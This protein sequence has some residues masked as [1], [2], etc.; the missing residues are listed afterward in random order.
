MNKVKIITDSCC[1]ITPDRLK[2]LDIDYV[3]M[4]FTVDGKT[5]N[6]FEHPKKNAKHFYDELAKCKSCSTSCV[7]TYNFTEIFTKYVSQGFD[8]FYI[9]LSGGLSATYSN[10]VSAAE[11]INT[12][13]QRVWVAD[14]LTGS[15][16]IALMIEHAVKLRDEGKSAAEIFAALD[17][18]HLNLYSIFVPG[19][20]NFLYRS[21]RISKLVA[22]IGSMLKLVPIITANEVGKLKMIAKCIGK[23]KARQTMEKFILSKADLESAETIYIG[24]TGIKAEAEAFA[25]FLKANTKKKTIIV[26]DIDYTMGCNC[27]PYTLAI[28]GKLK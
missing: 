6:G 5:F 15:F 17:K 19:D 10:A 27:G 4:S 21:G 11:E 20:I 24:H 14:S 28:F 8:V 2:A 18:N 1:S 26:G 16:G 12:A 22:C 7:N 23:N 9:G 25:E 13:G 3:Q